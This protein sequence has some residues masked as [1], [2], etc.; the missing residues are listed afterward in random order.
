[1]ISFGMRKFDFR[2]FLKRHSQCRNPK[3][4][5]FKKKAVGPGG[6]TAIVCNQ[7]ALVESGQ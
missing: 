2:F 3:D 1:M 7:R 4:G 5:A 6:S